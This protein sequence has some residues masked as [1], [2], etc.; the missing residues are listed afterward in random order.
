MKDLG[1]KVDRYVASEICEDSIA[2]AT[3]NHGGKISHVGDVRCITQ[4]LVRPNVNVLLGPRF[5]WV[6]SL[7]TSSVSPN[8]QIAKWGPFDLLIGGSPCNDLSI[9]NP[10]RK[11]LY[12]R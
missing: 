4:E 11:G 8:E 12:G 6:G 7:Y 1:F 2:I 3:V 5:S 9:V 10:L